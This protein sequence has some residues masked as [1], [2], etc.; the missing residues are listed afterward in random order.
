MT[1]IVDIAERRMRCPRCR[2]SSAILTAFDVRPG[3]QYLTMLCNACSIV[4]GAQVA[5]SERHE[6]SL[7]PGRRHLAPTA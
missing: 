4:F 3:F 6:G 7:T 1:D 2:A 5:T